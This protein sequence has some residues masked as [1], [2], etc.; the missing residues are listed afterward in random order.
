ML[1]FLTAVEL[2][3]GVSEAESHK[4]A[5][6]CSE[7]RYPQ[8]ATIFSEGDPTDSLYVLKKGRIKLIS[9]SEKGTQ[10]ILHILKPGEIFGEFLL[11]Q[12]KRPFAAVAIEDVHAAVIPRDSFLVLL[13]TVP[14]V[15]LNFIRLLSRRL[16]K[17]EQEL[18]DFS[19]TWSYNRLAKVLL[20]LSKEH[21]VETPQG[22]RIELRLTHEDL[23]NFIGTT[24]ETVTTQ[25]NKFQRMGF[26]HRE[27]RHLIVNRPRL[28]EFMRSEQ[29]ESSNP[30]FK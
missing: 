23:A 20:Q 9:L 8:G 7:R 13:S 15:A 25:L 26:L 16:M 22:T 24:R 29:M 1:P 5:S 21:G 11:V 6:L 30:G 28:I 14:T 2:F 27:N 12:Q 17:V 18:G 10:T 4:I 19:H 3:H